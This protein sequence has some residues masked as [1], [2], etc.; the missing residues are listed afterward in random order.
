MGVLVF[1]GFVIDDSWS[2][3]W[4]LHKALEIEHGKQGTTTSLMF[5]GVEDKSKSS[6]FDIVPV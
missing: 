6:K 1:A 5:E 4:W 3:K 2:D